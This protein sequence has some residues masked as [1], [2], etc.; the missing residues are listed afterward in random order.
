MCRLY[1]LVIFLLLVFFT[2][3]IVSVKMTKTELVHFEKI[4]INMSY[5]F[6]PQHQYAV[7]MP[8]CRHNKNCCL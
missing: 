3:I 1:W 4:Q 7:C 2:K 8:V 5:Y 6:L